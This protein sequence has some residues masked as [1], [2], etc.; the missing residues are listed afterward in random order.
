M[1]LSGSP[2]ILLLTLVSA[3]KW[4]QPRNEQYPKCGMEFLASVTPPPLLLYTLASRVVRTRKI[5]GHYSHLHCSFRC[6]V[7][8]DQGDMALKLV[9]IVTHQRH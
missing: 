4:L 8:A 6:Q 2:H 9:R 3:F 1:P 5:R 7:P